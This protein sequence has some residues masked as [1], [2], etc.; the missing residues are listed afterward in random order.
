MPAPNWSQQE[1][2][3]LRNRFT[4]TCGGTVQAFNLLHTIMACCMSNVGQ[5]TRVRSRECNDLTQWNQ[6]AFSVSGPLLVFGVMSGCKMCKSGRDPCRRLARFAQLFTQLNP[7]TGSVTQCPQLLCPKKFNCTVC[8]HACIGTVFLAFH[9]IQCPACTLCGEGKLQALCRDHG[10]PR[11]RGSVLGA[12][13]LC[14]KTT[15][16]AKRWVLN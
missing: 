13:R 2:S 4:N 9:C 8:I 1:Q 3:A 5:V 11:S 6:R 12:S 16:A 7:T 14:T 15:P 10:V